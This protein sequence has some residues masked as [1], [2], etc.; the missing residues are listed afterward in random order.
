MV[1]DLFDVVPDGLNP[2]V[3]GWLVYDKSKDL[4]EPTPVDEFNDFDDITLVPQDGE[5]LYD[6]VDHSITLDM[7]MDNLGDGAN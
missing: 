1:Q 6:K 2:N 5:A 4:P 3:T 7:K